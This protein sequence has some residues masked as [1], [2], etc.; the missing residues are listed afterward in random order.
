MK[1]EFFFFNIVFGNPRGNFAIFDTLSKRWCKSKNSRTF[2][3]PFCN[4]AE[5]KVVVK[6][7]SK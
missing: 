1:I 4:C 7:Y 5:R 3:M 6:K 2:S